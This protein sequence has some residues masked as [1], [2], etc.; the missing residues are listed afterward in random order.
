MTVMA[1]YLSVQ[2][3]PPADAGVVHGL[4]CTASIVTVEHH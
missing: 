2:L 1:V 4:A 3:M